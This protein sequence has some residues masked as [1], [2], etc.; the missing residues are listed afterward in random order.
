V[1]P[2]K[3]ALSG[4]SSTGDVSSTPVP[5]TDLGLAERCVPSLGS[6]VNPMV[7]SALLFEV[8]GDQVLVVHLVYVSPEMM[9]TRSGRTFDEVEILIDRVRGALYQSE[10]SRPCMW[11]HDGEPVPA[12][13]VPWFRVGNMTYQVAWRY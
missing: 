1:R 9:S 12:D 13:H 7:T 5:A 3:H 8:K 6:R 11:K 2:V 4:F 10:A